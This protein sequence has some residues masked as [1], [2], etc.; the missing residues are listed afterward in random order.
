MANPARSSSCLHFRSRV[1]PA[2][3]TDRATDVGRS[4]TVET[5]CVPVPVTD[6]RARL[7]ND[8]GRTSSP[9]ITLREDGD[10]TDLGYVRSVVRPGGRVVAV[11]SDN[12]TTSRT[13]SIGATVLDP[14]KP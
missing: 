5:S 4:R 14:G 1:P 6:I 9:A 12:D 2:D 10:N 13:Q 3:R 8:R 11:Y 7:S